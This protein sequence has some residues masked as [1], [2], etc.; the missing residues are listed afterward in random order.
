MAEQG[1]LVFGRGNEPPRPAPV[2]RRN[3]AAFLAAALPAIALGATMGWRPRPL[4]VWNAS[5]SSPTG[6]YRVSAAGAPR[7]GTMVVAWLPDRIRRLAAERHYL[8]ANVPLVKR[9][10]A[11]AGDRVCADGDRIFINGRLAARRRPTDLS[12]RP[13][14]WWE[15]CSRLGRGEIF[16]LSRRGPA[17]FDSRYFG[18][19]GAGLVVGEARLIWAR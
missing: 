6:L 2:R 4:L 11:S 18:I 9:V 19:I 15:G 8:P 5:A 10:G 14:P 17:S 13:M 12:G 1:T 3:V 7:R 16:L